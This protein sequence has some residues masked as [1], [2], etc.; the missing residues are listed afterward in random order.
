MTI[1]SAVALSIVPESPKYLYSKGSFEACRKALVFINKFNGRN[2]DVMSIR[3]DTELK[4][5]E[6]APVL[7]GGKIS[8]LIGDRNHRRNLGIFIV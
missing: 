3:F 4:K 7:V 6:G 1:A 5:D 2:H 8:D